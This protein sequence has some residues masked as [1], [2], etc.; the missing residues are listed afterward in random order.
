V[1][2]VLIFVLKGKTDA[3]SKASPLQAAYGQAPLA[4]LS[5]RTEL[6]QLSELR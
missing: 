3:E 5:D 6:E 4:R 2:I 1:A